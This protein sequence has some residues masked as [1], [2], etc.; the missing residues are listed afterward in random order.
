M[1]ATTL[2]GDTECNISKK[3]LMFCE[4]E[5]TIYDQNFSWMGKIPKYSNVLM[6]LTC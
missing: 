2:S 4:N 3:I 1:V 6:N 5:C